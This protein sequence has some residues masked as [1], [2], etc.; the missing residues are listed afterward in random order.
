MTAKTLTPEQMETRT[1]RFNKLQTYQRQ[2]FDAHNIPPGAVE[3]VQSADGSWFQLAQPNSITG[4]IISSGSSII[5]ATTVVAGTSISAGTFIEAATEYRVA[6]DKVL[7]RR[8]P[9][10]VPQPAR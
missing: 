3:K 1:A 7:G 5:A 9:D 2:N 10:G 8:S 4:G 6:G